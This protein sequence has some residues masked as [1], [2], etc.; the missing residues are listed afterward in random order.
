MDETYIHPD[1]RGNITAKSLERKHQ[2]GEVLFSTA[3]CRL[4]FR[5]FAVK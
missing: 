3:V 1:Y 4:T 5:P 2:T